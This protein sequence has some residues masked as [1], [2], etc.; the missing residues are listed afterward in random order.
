MP[1]QIPRTGR[2]QPELPPAIRG[3]RLFHPDRDRSK[4]LATRRCNPSR[5]GPPVPAPRCGIRACVPALRQCSQSSPHRVAAHVIK[6]GGSSST[7]LRSWF[8]E[9]SSCGFSN[10]RLVHRLAAFGTLPQPAQTNGGRYRI[11][12]YD[13]HRV[14]TSVLGFRRTCKALVGFLSPTSPDN[15]DLSQAGAQ[16]GIPPELAPAFV[17]GIGARALQNR[18]SC[19][20]SCATERRVSVE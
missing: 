15:R 10:D 12:T 20:I 18:P 14:K 17:D 8:S 3:P 1:L 9:K 7:D 11:R 19:S 5:D 13:F 4:Q 16:A 2:V 6:S